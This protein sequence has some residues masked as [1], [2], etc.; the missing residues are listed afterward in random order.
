LGEYKGVI[1]TD[2]Q[3]LLENKKGMSLVGKKSF[4]VSSCDLRKVINKKEKSG[5]KWSK[6]DNYYLI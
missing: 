1:I 3:C 4:R 2:M 5:V 6:V